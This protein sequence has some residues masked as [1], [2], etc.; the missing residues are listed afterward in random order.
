MPV[1]LTWLGHATW[2]VTTP[3]GRLLIDPFLD[4]NPSA[5]LRAADIECDA[6]LITHG[7]FDHIADAVSIAKRTKAKVFCNWEIAQWLGHHGVSN[8]Q[9]MNHGG[10]V[11]IPGGTVK[12]EIAFH[13]SMLPDGANGGSPAGFTLDLDGTRVYVAGD[14][15]IFSDMHLIGRAGLDAAIVPIG[16]VFTMGP[17]DAIEAI[18]LLAPKHALPSHYGTWPPIEQDADAWA[19]AIRAKKL[20]EPHVLRPGGSIRVG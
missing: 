6:I 14:T 19:A 3:A 5:T 12:M 13:S 9:P 10:R 11:K 20:A 1:E 7:H 18:R 8:C 17:E 2:L 15:A 4:E 16:D